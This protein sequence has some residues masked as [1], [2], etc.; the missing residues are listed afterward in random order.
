MNIEV[1]AR[2]IGDNVNRSVPVILIEE[3]DELEELAKSWLEIKA[4]AVDTEFERRTTFYAKLALLQVYDGQTIYLI[5]PLKTDCPQS[6]KGIFANNS[7]V[8]ILHS[9]KEDIE[10]LFTEWGCKIANLFD[11]QVAYHMVEDEASIGYARLVEKFT[12]VSLSKQQTQSD[13]IKR[14]LSSAQLKYAANDVLYLIYIYKILRTRL[15]ELNLNDLFENECSEIVKLSIERVILPADYREAK[16]VNLL[17]S[18]DLSLFKLLFEWREAAARKDNRTKNHIIKD[19]QLVQMAMLKPLNKGALNGLS[20][21]HPRSTRKY[22]DSWISIV[23]N[24]KNS[25]AI[26]LPIVVNPRDIAEIKP[27]VTEW[28]KLIKQVAKQ[29]GIPATLIMSKRIMRKLAYALITKSAPPAIW[30][31]WRKKL[32][33]DMLI[34]KTKQFVNI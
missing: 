13:W 23:D 10:V 25:T 3:F 1:D 34:E 18:T 20:D 2:I 19:Q 12:N 6:L 21:L 11:T 28:E 33:Q 26:S 14:P 16:E 7:I 29:K 22:A 32:L 8:K 24:W 15:V 4:L 27:L 31:G 5:D 30:S 17:N 9:C